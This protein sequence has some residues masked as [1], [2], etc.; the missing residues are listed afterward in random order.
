ME[1]IDNKLSELIIKEEK[2]YSPPKRVP[3]SIAQTQTDN[4]ETKI[5]KIEMFT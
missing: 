1:S 5:E 2:R 3:L 4:I